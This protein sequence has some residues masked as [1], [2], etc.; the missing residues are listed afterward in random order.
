MSRNGKIRAAI[1][2]DEY[3]AA[4]LL[5]NM[6]SSLRPEWEITL[7]PGSIEEAV[8]WFADNPHPDLLFL[9]IQL[10]DGNSFMFL[11]QAHP[12]SMIVFTTAYDEYAVKAFS[13]NSIDYL[14]KPINEERLRAAVEKFERLSPDNITE[15]N[16]LFDVRGVIEEL[17]N[18]VQPRF[19][20]RILV[21]SGR[22]FYA[23]EVADIAYFYSEDK[24]TFAVTKDGKRHVIDISLGKL[25]EQ[26][27]GKL[28]FRANRQFILSAESIRRIEPYNNNKLNIRVSPVFDG[29]ISISKEKITS[30]KMW[31]NS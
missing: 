30:L 12:S 27:D 24:I 31:L 29:A 13:V 17:V 14:L 4:R 22:H 3:P 1:I 9:D 16:N 21:T 28:F 2:E 23:I 26:L 7:L 15:L 8:R 6:L 19:R 18:R 25:E 20:T 5:C 11:E 10:T